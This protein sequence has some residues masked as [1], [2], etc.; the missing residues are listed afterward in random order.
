MKINLKLKKILNDKIKKNKDG[1]ERRKK[2]EEKIQKKKKKRK[3]KVT[4]NKD[5]NDK[6]E[7]VIRIM[8]STEFKNFIF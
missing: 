5:G 3:K 2:E 4:K 1:N 7:F 8:D 6:I